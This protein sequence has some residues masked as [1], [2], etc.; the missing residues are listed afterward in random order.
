MRDCGVIEG[1]LSPK[2]VRSHRDHIR[3]DYLSIFPKILFN[4]RRVLSGKHL[5]PGRILANTFKYPA[6]NLNSLGFIQIRAVY[7][8]MNLN[9]R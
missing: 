8:N 5:M 6:H 4:L 3:D 2:C 7:L 1:T 9:K